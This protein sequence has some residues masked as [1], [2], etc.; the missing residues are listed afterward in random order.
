MSSP[1][2]RDPEGHAV[3]D[4]ELTM[5]GRTLTTPETGL[6]WHNTISKETKSQRLPAPAL[7]RRAESW[8][9]QV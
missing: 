9:W 3:V 4:K 6:K 5:G 8:L 7:M 1:G 2:W